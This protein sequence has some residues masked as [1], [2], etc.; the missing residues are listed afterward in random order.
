MVMVFTWDKK[1]ESEKQSINNWKQK[2]L[3]RQ[4]ELRSMQIKMRD[5]Q[6][7]RNKWKIEAKEKEKIIKELEKENQELKGK[8][9][10]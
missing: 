6:R 5:L 1:M 4:Q 10:R 9:L 7:S 2:A 8:K 3:V